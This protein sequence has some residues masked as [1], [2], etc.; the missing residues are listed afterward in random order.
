MTGPLLKISEL[1]HRARIVLAGALL[2]LSTGPLLAQIVPPP[3]Y[4]PATTVQIVPVAGKPSAEKLQILIITGRHSYEHD[5]R[6]TTNMLRKMLEDTGRFDVR[7][8]EEFR[9]ASE[10]TLK[11]YD[12]VLINYVGRWAYTDKEEIRWG[13]QAEKALFDFVRNGGGVVVYHTSLALGEPSWPEFEKMVGGT[14]RIAQSRRSPPNAF[15]VHVVNRE[16]PITRGMREYLWTFDDD[17]L[18]NLKWD[19][20]VKVNVLVTGFDDPASYAPKLAGPKYPP[21]LYPADKLATLPNMGKENP[22]VWTTQYGRGRV[23]CMSLGHGPDTLQYDGVTS[24][25]VRGAEWA[26]SG[27]VTVPLKDNAQAFAAEQVQD[28]Q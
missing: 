18:T 7:V 3:A 14:L 26:A 21:E 5:W 11:H 19:P 22:L 8:T 16:D 25:I 28:K 1:L 2:L 4:V 17:M 12:A 9:G 15:T 20:S 24:L 13:P 23:Y 10:E 6:G 27:K